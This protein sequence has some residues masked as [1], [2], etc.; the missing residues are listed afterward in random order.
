MFK[1]KLLY[2]MAVIIL[3]AVFSIAGIIACGGGTDI[4]G[5]SGSFSTSGGEDTGNGGGETTPTPTPTPNQDDNYTLPNDNPSDYYKVRVPFAVGGDGF[6]NVS[7]KDT[8]RLR[9]LWLDQINRKAVN[10]GKVFAIRNRGNNADPNTFQKT[11]THG[12]FKALDYYYF[13]ENGDIVYKEDNTIIKKF[14]GAI[15][16][17]YRDVHTQRGHRANFGYNDNRRA[18]ISITW[19][20]KG[21][22]T[23]GAIYANTLTTEEAKKKYHWDSTGNNPFKDGVYDFITY[24]HQVE[25]FHNGVTFRN[26]WF[27]RQYINPGFIEVLVM[28]DYSNDDFSGAASV[29]S[30]YAYY[31]IYNYYKEYANHPGI[32]FTPQNMPYMTNQNIYLGQRP[33]YIDRQLNHTAVFTDSF[34]DWCYLFMPGHKN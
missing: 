16:T 24:R 6:T 8:N 10:D 25:T 15:I 27:E 3:I 22:Y 7:Y 12:Q 13:N 1:S 5:S 33:E 20:K 14:V 4:T 26:D 23:V 2:R 28:Y 21:V 11:R 17:E 32:Y 30:Y 18:I 29:H 9:K 34:R 31:G 19:N